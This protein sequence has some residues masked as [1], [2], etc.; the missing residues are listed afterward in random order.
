MLQ[1]L[2]KFAKRLGGTARNFKNI[3]I[4]CKKV[5]RSCKSNMPK[6]GFERPKLSNSHV[7]PWQLT[8]HTRVWLVCLMVTET[9][10]T[11]SLIRHEITGRFS[12][13]FNF[14]R[15]G[16]LCVL[17]WPTIGRPHHIP[18]NRTNSFVRV[19][20]GSLISALKLVIGTLRV[21]SGPKA[22][23]SK[24]LSSAGIEVN[25]RVDIRCVRFD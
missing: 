4:S 12:L 9:H 3:R 7:L 2:W 8:C 11:P 19:M 15:T 22:P 10:Q 25:N 13:C 20:C 6:Q 24:L 1:K 16:E 14:Q 5:K 17:F 23:R 21:N 18:W